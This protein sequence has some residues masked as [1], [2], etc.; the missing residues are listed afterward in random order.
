MSIF[1]MIGWL[2]A[3]FFILAYFLLSID[4]LKSDGIIYQ[5][6]NVIGGLCM[7]I[8]SINL[9]DHPNLVTNFIWMCIG[10][11]AVTKIISKR[12]KKRK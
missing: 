11:F 4:N 12:V 7:V 10:L 3:I 2:G 9:N 5:L 6:M 8:N 1:E